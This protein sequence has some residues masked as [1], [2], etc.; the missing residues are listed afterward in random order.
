MIPDI[1]DE[2]WENLIL[3]IDRYQF[4]LLS[5]KI[6]MNRTFISIKRDSSRENIEKCKRDI[7]EFFVKNEK[8]SQNDLSHIFDRNIK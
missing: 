1:A 2:R 3:G 5:V 7:Y 8:I 4:H 6:L